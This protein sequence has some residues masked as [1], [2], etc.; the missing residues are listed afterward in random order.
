M[1]YS[2]AHRDQR[3]VKGNGFLLVIVT[4]HRHTRMLRARIREALPSRHSTVDEQIIARRV[5][6]FI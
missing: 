6:A 5:R 1:G 3:S 4:S 2:V